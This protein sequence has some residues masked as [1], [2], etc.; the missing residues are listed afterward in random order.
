MPSGTSLALSVRKGNTPTPDDGTWTN[1]VELA[2]SGAAIGGIA[3]YLQ[4]R[5]VLA[6]SSLGQ[7]PALQNVT[8]QYAPNAAPVANNDAYSTNEDTAL[9]VATPGVLGNDTAARQT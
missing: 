3:R 1:F 2:S 8:I 4:Y 9:T 5:A 7:T 6:T